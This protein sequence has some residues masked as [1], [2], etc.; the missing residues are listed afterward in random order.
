MARRSST[1]REM[2]SVARAMA[3]AGGVTLGAPRQASTKEGAGAG[4]WV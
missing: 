1:R 2:S 4:S 3:G